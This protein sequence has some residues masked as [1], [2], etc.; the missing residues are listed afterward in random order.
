MSESEAHRNLVVSTAKKIQEFHPHMSVV[1]DVQ[2]TPG[3]PVPPKI[4][5]YRPDIIARSS[6]LSGDIIIA[7]AKTP[8]DIDRHHTFCQIEVF[9]KH[10]QAKRYNGG[11]F[12]L[13]VTGAE[14]CRKAR[15][16]LYYIAREFVSS[17][18]QVQ[19]FDGLDFW[20]L[21]APPEQLW[22]LS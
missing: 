17:R 18:L 3:A 9:L 5:G 14:A 12:V 10:L 1:S 13:A 19:L 22:H 21:G 7:E 15:G 20:T 8:R 2:E 11:T 6:S 16:L 4:D